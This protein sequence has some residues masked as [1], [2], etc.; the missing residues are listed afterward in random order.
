MSRSRSVSRPY[1]S[2]IQRITLLIGL[3]HIYELNFY[4]ELCK[5]QKMEKVKRKMAQNYPTKRQQ[6]KM[7]TLNH[8]RTSANM[9]K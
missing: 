9:T 4:T 7:F 1:S 2:L 8:L 6:L 3:K 5:T